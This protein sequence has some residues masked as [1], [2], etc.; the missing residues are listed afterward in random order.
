M[1]TQSET[2]TTPGQGVPSSDLFG[3][4]DLMLIM[5]DIEASHFR[6][7]HDTGANDCAL[8]IWNALR[9]RV[10]LPW[11]EKKHLP[12]WDGIRYVMPGVSNLLPSPNTELRD[13]ADK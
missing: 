6:T 5:R 3:V 11:L 13:A 10:G 1:T 7:E 2:T 12:A 9:Q 8:L 4:G